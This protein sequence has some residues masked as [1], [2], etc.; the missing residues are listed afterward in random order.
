MHKGRY[1][2]NAL[3]SGLLIPLGKVRSNYLKL[4]KLGTDKASD[5]AKISQLSGFWL[6]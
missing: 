3:I 4:E 6:Q 5:L 1:S 2:N